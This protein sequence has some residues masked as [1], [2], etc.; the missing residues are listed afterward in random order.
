MGSP[1][2]PRCHRVNLTPLLHRRSCH[3]EHVPLGPR[4]GQPAC[5][6]HVRAAEGDGKVLTAAGRRRSPG[7][8]GSASTL[9][10]DTR[11][12]GDA[13]PRPPLL[14]ARRRAGRPQPAACARLLREHRH[15]EDV[16]P[17]ATVEQ[18]DQGQRWRTRN[19]Y[20]VTRQSGAPCQRP[21]INRESGSA[22][23]AACR[24]LPTA[25]LVGD[26]RRSDHCHSHHLVTQLRLTGGSGSD[27]IPVAEARR[28]TSER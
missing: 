15:E 7:S 13:G 9:V 25:P 16:Q 1:S 17:T 24:L 4:G 28:S 20:T 12:P 3:R 18:A 10:C 27:G 2:L 22:E 26:S 11:S 5:H 6:L 14:L 8:P 19:P 23:V 21:H